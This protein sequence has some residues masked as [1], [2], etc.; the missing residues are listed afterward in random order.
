M[1]IDGH[2][3]VE[4]FGYFPD[5]Q[6]QIICIWWSVAYNTELLITQNIT[7]FDHYSLLNRKPFLIQFFVFDNIIS[8]HVLS[9]DHF[10]DNTMI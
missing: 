3:I 8:I 9:G 2:D 10:C 6:T 4:F 7:L 5:F 1:L